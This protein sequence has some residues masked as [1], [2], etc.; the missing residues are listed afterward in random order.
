MLRETSYHGALGE[1]FAA[2]SETS[3]YN[4]YID[5]PAML[6]LAGDVAGL[7]TDRARGDRGRDRWQR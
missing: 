6:A 3:N 7:G 1:A 2:H 4:A 5:R